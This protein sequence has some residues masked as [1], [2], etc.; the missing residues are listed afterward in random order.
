LVK[1]DVVRRHQGAALG[2]FGKG[3]TTMTNIQTTKVLSDADLDAVVGGLPPFLAAF[4]INKVEHSNEPKA[5]QAMQIHNIE[6]ATRW[7]I[8]FHR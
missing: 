4:E 8:F 2:R 5:V 1:A 7:P 6:A 3:K